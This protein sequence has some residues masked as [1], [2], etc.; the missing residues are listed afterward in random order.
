MSSN[1][2]IL[3]LAFPVL[4]ICA[5]NKENDKN[6]ATQ[7]GKD[8]YY[9]DFLWK[10]HVPDTLYREMAFDFNDDAR[11]F[12]YEPLQ[13]GLFKKTDSGKMLPVMENEMEVFVDGT[14]CENNVISVEPGT[15][16]IKVGLVFNPAAENKVHHWFIK[17]VN[18]GGLERIND[19]DAGTFNNPES[20][21]MEVEA[22]KNK[23]MNPLAEGSMLTGIFLLAALLVWLFVLKLI[24][25][26]TFRVGKIILSDPV[27]YMSQKR[28]RGTRKL[29]LTNNKPTQSGINR[30]FTGKIIYDVNPMWTSDIVIEP[31]DRNSVRVRPSKE[32]MTDTHTMK[33][34]NEYTIQNMT[35]GT[36]TKV[37]IS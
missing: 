7:W 37:K 31:R 5:C 8:N 32:Y 12:M 4:L 15:E 34:H 35:T 11:N 29:I 2:L 13:L 24:F 23:I 3:F 25:F 28:L 33:V 22:E 10:K 21:L 6:A 30:F 1:R 14:K 27:P 9:N 20:S 18:D 16:I 19:M 26:P 17:P 36:K